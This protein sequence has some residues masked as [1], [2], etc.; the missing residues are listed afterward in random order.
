MSN[1]TDLLDRLRIWHDEFAPSLRVEGYVVEFTEPL[2]TRAKPSA[3][4]LVGSTRRIAKLTVWS[5]GEAELDL[6]DA[7]SGKATMEH[8]EVTGDLGLTDA[9]HT[10]VEWVRGS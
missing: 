2:R 8:R 3:S 9:T 5:T 7:I 1:A 10:L 4:V 6:G